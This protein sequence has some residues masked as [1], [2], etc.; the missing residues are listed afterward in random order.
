MRS[1]DPTSSQVLYRPAD[2]QLRQTTF[3]GWRDDNNPKD[4]VLERLS[5]VLHYWEVTYP[6]PFSKKSMGS[7]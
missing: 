2:E 6:L 5:R 1:I 7:V 3:R 4:V